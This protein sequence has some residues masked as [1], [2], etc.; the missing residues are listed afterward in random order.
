MYYVYILASR[1][2]GTLYI[3]VTNNILGR[4]ELH[5]AGK[6][7]VFTSRYRVSMLVYFEEFNDI[8]AAIQREKTLKHYARDWKLE[9]CP[10]VPAPYPP[11]S[12][13]LRIVAR[14]RSYAPGSPL[15]CT[16]P[17]I[18]AVPRSHCNLL[19]RRET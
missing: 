15:A 6:G 1:K 12:G 10:S 17:E 5:R 4:I 19:K 7:S 3:G 14:P 18:P 16:T 8:K 2:H 9:L 13:A 11:Q